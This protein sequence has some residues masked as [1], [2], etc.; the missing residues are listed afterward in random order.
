[1][2]IRSTYRDNNQMPSLLKALAATFV[3]GS[4]PASLLAQVTD[5]KP[6]PPVVTV[7]VDATGNMGQ[8][9]PH[10]FGTFIEP[11]DWSVNNGVMAQI[12]DNP[13][14]EA[15]LY[16]HAMF[17]PIFK[18]QPELIEASDK[19]GIPFPWKQLNA[20]AG[21]R[22]ELHVGHAANSWQSLEVF[23]LPHEQVGIAQRVY[24]PVPRE[25]KYN[26][27]L[28]A[29]HVSGPTEL[30]VLLRD[31]ATKAVLGTA[32][33]DATSGDWTKYTATIELKPGSAKRLQAVEFGVAVTGIGRVELDEILLTPADAVDGV[34]DPDVLKLAAAMNMTEL[35]FGGNFSSYYHWRDGVG[36]ADKRLTMENI[37]WGIPEYN[38]FGT[39]EFLD[40]AK[41][42]HAEP[43]F[44]VNEG[45]GS[46]QEAEDWIKY[47]RERYHGPMVVEMGN[48]LYGAWQVAYPTVDQVGPRTLD[49]SKAIKPL[50]QPGDTLMATGT[51]PAGSDQWNAKQYANPAGTFDLLTMHFIVGTNNVKLKPYTPDFMA[52]AA[53]VV[54]T[55]MG[56]ELDTLEKKKDAFPD[57]K[58]AHF[59]V[60][61]WLFNNKSAGERH[62]ENVSPSSRNQGG[63]VMI[64]LSYNEYFRHNAEI[65]L[66]DMTGLMEFAGIWKRKEVAFVSPPYYTLQMYSTAK[67]QTVV[68]VTTDSGAYDVVNGVGGYGNVKD[69][70]YVDVV[71]TKSEDGKS[72]TLFC[73][74]RS[75]TAD[76]PLKI[77][78]KGFAPTGEVEV[79]RIVSKDRLEMNTE[80]NPE[81]V[82][83]M[84]SMMPAP[85]GKALEVTIPHESVMVVRLHQ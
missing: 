30:E 13:S 22:Y 10:I 69:V 53:Y 17:E 25:W 67:G 59:A 75:L 74:N 65:K 64:A 43:Q 82:K 26:V 61:E 48:E 15:G 33:M 45:S 62:F 72:L 85:A 81:N 11:I 24:L 51:G 40:F 71:A 27:S 42:V 77:D 50:L 49:F 70:P 44:D 29:K 12:L 31:P 5:A 80:E 66:V 21:N 58:N 76:E 34:F 78:L 16:N 1:M 36:P 4:L 8:V 52:A 2:A 6:M 73:V 9:S 7:N 23:G 3:L 46:P 68:P 18:E 37:A 84:K 60:T 56:R 35:R 28:Y 41:L 83:P 55:G 19:T 20:A 14:L 38:N 39:D 63:A 32:K 79:D 47:I 57:M 54:P